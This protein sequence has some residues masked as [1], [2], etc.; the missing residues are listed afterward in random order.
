M[1]TVKKGHYRWIIY[2]D[3]QDWLGV[4]LEFNIIVSG[5]DPQVVQAELHEAALGYIESAKNLKGFRD[6]QVNKILNQKPEEEYEKLWSSAT[7]QNIK[8][9]KITSPFS[10]ED[11]YS[12]GVSNLQVA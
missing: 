7:S 8:Q 4:A 12:A 1:N 9:E 2:R 11:V 3:G 5:S 6:A 10:R